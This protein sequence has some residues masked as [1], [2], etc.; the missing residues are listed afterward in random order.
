MGFMK[1]SSLGE[2][3]II[4]EIWRILDRNIEYDDCAIIE[5]EE[6]TL[7]TTDFIGEGTH[8]M[9]DWEYFIIGK[10]FASINLS[11]IAAMGGKPEF[12][13]ASMFFPQDFELEKLGQLI[14]GMEKQLRKYEVKYLG[15]DMKEAKIAGMSGIAVGKVEKDKILR[16]KGAK[17][18]EGIY[19]TGELG[20][21]AA[22]YYLWKNG[23]EEGW[24]YL[25][26]VEPRIKEGRKLAGK[27]SSCMDLSDGLLHTLQQMEKTNN[28]GFRVDFDTLPI[29]PLAYEVSEDFHIPLEL[30]ALSFGGEYELLFT[31]TSHILG[32]EI[33]VVEKNGGI[34]RNGKKIGGEGYAHF[35]KALD[36]IRGQ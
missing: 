35:S 14:K 9:D 27:A 24:K 8:F 10:F 34:W 22:G 15:G 31:S 30:L 33:G 17:M 1:L 32:K 18:G 3:G 19:L 13:L 28:L 16:R 36:K 23:Y 20:K 7:I 5:G 26:E 25:L 2:R 4:D 29:H 6:Y 12:F 11:D 21:Q